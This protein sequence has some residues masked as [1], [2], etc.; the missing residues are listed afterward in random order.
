VA[1]GNRGIR[2]FA[3][4]S[5]AWRR[6]RE[7]QAARLTVQITLYSTICSTLELNIHQTTQLCSNTESEISETRRLNWQF[8]S[9]CVPT[10]ASAQ[11]PLVVLF[12]L[13]SLCPIHSSFSQPH[14][15]T[16]HLPASS[17]SST[18]AKGA[19]ASQASAL[20]ARGGRSSTGAPAAGGQVV[21]R[22]PGGEHDGR[23]SSSQCASCLAVH[24]LPRC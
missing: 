6:D 4:R 10:P 7:R 14:Y 9:A 21:R 11:S 1:I 13:L 8:F 3:P 23:P 16:N 24:C 18:M 22:R 2:R 5:S 12:S 20:V 17:R 19:S 15:P